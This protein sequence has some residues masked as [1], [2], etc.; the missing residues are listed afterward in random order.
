MADDVLTDLILKIK[1]IRIGE[2]TLEN[3]RPDLLIR[4]AVD[5]LD[6][7]PENT[8]QILCAAGDDM[9]ATIHLRLRLVRVASIKGR[10]N[11]VTVAVGQHATVTITDRGPYVKGRCIDLSKAGAS[12]LGFAGLVPVSIVPVVSD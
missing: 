1:M 10:E 8:I 11:L 3:I 5:D 9:G 6:I 12:A 2:L 7:D 4:T